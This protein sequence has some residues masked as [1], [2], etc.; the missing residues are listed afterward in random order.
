MV[1]SVV[2]GVALVLNAY[3]KLDIVNTVAPPLLHASTCDV[4]CSRWGACHQELFR[5]LAAIAIGLP[6]SNFNAQVDD[7]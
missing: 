7:T 5:H 6:G 1:W 3:A 4:Q 2:Q